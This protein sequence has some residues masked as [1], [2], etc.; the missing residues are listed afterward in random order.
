MSGVKLLAWKSIGNSDR[1]TKPLIWSVSQ[2]VYQLNYVSYGPSFCA[3]LATDTVIA[4]RTEIRP[5]AQYP[6]ATGQTLAIGANGDAKIV[7]GGTAGAVT[8]KNADT[9]SLICGLSQVEGSSSSIVPYCAATI[10]PGFEETFY[11]VDKVLLAF[12]SADLVEGEYITALAGS[13]A[14]QLD[15]ASGYRVEAITSS[16][17][18]LVDLTSADSRSVSYSLDKGW[19]IDLWS[20][21][22]PADTLLPSILIQGD[23]LA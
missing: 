11:P 8:V 4:E 3:Y 9:V 6:I 16:S 12:S 23:G 19:S 5:N 13:P 17:M 15:A 1:A 22:Y 18:L 7:N 14:S 2:S 10:Y 20:K 21:T